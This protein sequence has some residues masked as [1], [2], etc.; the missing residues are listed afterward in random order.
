MSDPLYSYSMPTCACFA[1]STLKKPFD[2]KHG[3]GSTRVWW[4][5]KLTKGWQYVRMP[6]QTYCW[7]IVKLN[8]WSTTHLW[9]AEEWW[10][11]PVDGP[12]PGSSC[13]LCWRNLNFNMIC[14]GLFVSRPASV[15]DRY[16]AHYN[17]FIIYA[18][19]CTVGGRWV[20]VVCCGDSA[21]A[22]HCVQ[23]RSVNGVLMFNSPP[24]GHSCCGTEGNYRSTVIRWVDANSEFTQRAVV[25]D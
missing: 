13:G 24:C 5:A 11:C 2:L 23:R 25:H 15:L 12:L 10:L 19:M 8:N 9:S 22:V 4:N 14:L 3:S 16:T 6:L 17:L 21:S 1:P 7:I 18:C 20:H